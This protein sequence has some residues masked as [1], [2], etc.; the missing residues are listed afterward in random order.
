MA[1][2]DNGNGIWQQWEWHLMTIMVFNGNGNCIWQQ[3]EWYS[4]IAR[5]VFDEN[6]GF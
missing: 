2:N 1:F 4:M 5:M 3:W 6:N